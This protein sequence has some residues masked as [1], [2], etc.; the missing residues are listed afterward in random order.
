VNSKTVNGCLYYI[1]WQFYSTIVLMTNS[2]FLTFFLDVPDSQKDNFCSRFHRFSIRVIELTI[3]WKRWIGRK[4]KTMIKLIII[5]FFYI[6]AVHIFNQSYLVRADIGDCS[7]VSFPWRRKSDNRNVRTIISSN[8][9]LLRIV[10]SA[11]FFLSRQFRFKKNTITIGFKLL[12]IVNEHTFRITI[13][14]F[15]VVALG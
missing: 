4:K 1:E 12:M 2:K 15:W 3:C 10:S 9:T 5:F 14:L 8:T 11:L 6:Y 13:F 7:N